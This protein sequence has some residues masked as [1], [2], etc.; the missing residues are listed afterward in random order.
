MF[1]CLR[2]GWGMKLE[3]LVVSVPARIQIITTT[4]NELELK[5]VFGYP[6]FNW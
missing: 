6:G 4:M 3:M 5:V 2:S 1:Q